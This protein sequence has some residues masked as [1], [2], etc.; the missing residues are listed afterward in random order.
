MLADWI[1]PPT[2]VFTEQSPSMAAGSE[3]TPSAQTTE[4]QKSEYHIEQ[5]PGRPVPPER[6]P[7]LFIASSFA[8]VTLWILYIG[9]RS[10][11]ICCAQKKATSLPW[12]NWTILFAEIMLSVEDILTSI[13]II[14]PLCTLKKFSVRPRYCLTGSSAPSIDVCVTCCGEP[15]DIVA[16][17]LVAAT[18]QDYPPDRFRVLLLDDGCNKTL[19]EVTEILSK[20]NMHSPQILYRSRKLDPGVP[21]Y[22]KAGNLQYGLEE[23]EKIGASQYFAVLD[24][25]MIPEPDWLRRAIPHLLLD[26]KVALACP[27]QVS[28]FSCSSNRGFLSKLCF[29]LK[30]RNAL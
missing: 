6:H 30:N 24:A 27:P 5:A 15:A 20:K 18:V 26:D 10:L 25:D 8:R 28:N 19:K 9:Y 3:M 14:Y 12:R 21:S 17:T 16:N 7:Y 4:G 29:V 1:L 2:S 13:G 23:T 11:C 22:Y